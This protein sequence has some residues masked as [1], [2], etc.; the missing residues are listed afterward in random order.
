MLRRKII[1][2]VHRLVHV[3]GKDHAAGRLADDLGPLEPA[4]QAF[5]LLLDAVRQLGRIRDQQAPRERIV[6][7]L[8]RQVR[9]DEVGPRLAVSHHHDLGRSRDAVHS[10]RPEHLFL[11]QGHVDVARPRDDVDARN[12]RRAVR[13]GRDRLCTPDPIHGVHS[14]EVRGGEDRGRNAPVR[15]WRCGEHKV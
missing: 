2:H 7:Q 13:Q 12:A 6:L 5:Q 3:V 15:A 4:H 11:G 10:H 1:G 9:G 14:R 8:R